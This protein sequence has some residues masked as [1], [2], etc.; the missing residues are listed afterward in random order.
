MAKKAPPSSGKLDEFG[1]PPVIR[2]ETLALIVGVGPRRLHQL[3]SD[4]RIEK[5]VYFGAEKWETFKALQAIFAYYR[6]QLDN[7]KSPASMDAELLVE[8][9]RAIKIKNAKSARE[10]LPRSVYIQ[11]FGELL[12]TFKTR[13]LGFADKM[14]ARVFRAKD[15]VEAAD[16]L[17]REVRSIFGALA[18]PAVMAELEAKIHDDEF[19]DGESADAPGTAGSEGEDLDSPDAP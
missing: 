12:T 3:L 10:L 4:G 17:D 8:N 16:I 13:W 5:D 1:L 7:K 19:S 11:V 9:L 2:T 14:A 18:D 15:K 6:R